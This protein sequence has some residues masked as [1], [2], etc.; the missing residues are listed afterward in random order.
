MGQQTP[1]HGSFAQWRYHSQ[2]ST[3]WGVVIANWKLNPIPAGKDLKHIPPSN[4][5]KPEKA[6]NL[7]VTAWIKIRVPLH[8][9]SRSSLWSSLWSKIEKDTFKI[10]I[11]SFIF[12]HAREWAKER[13]SGASE[14]TSEWPST[15]IWVHGYSGIWA[16][17]L[18]TFT[19]LIS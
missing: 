13:V 9:V 2:W 15:Y 8:V 18:F 7:L 6:G 5:C 17:V 16:I 1:L 11:Q 3:N 14:R 19:S 12:P 10:A 4:F